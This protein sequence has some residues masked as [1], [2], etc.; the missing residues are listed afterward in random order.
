MSDNND[1]YADSTGLIVTCPTCGQKNRLAYRHLGRPAR[2]P[3]S[4]T[5]LS[6]PPVPIAIDTTEAFDALIAQSPLPVFVDFWAEWCGPCHMVAPEVAKVAAKLA[7]QVVVAKVDTEALQDVS[8]RFG[9]RS[10]PMMAL[11]IGGREAGR[12]VG[13]RPASDLI[14]FINETTAASAVRP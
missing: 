10:I 11:F 13:A 8:A 14:T 12:T 6:L 7:G 1:L 2:C 5:A 9:I 3:K 4:Q